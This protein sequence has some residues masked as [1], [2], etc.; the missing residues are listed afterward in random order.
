MEKF[1]VCN[2]SGFYCGSGADPEGSTGRLPSSGLLPLSSWLLEW[3]A[4]RGNSEE[5]VREVVMV[6]RNRVE[7]AWEE[8]EGRLSDQVVAGT[9]NGRVAAA[10]QPAGHPG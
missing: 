9:G 7:L 1:Q 10:A 2:F 4:V 5:D 3:E 8:Q 6:N